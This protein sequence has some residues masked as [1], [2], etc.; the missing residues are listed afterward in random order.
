MNHS[1]CYSYARCQCLRHLLLVVFKP[2]VLHPVSTATYNS[3]DVLLDLLK[4]VTVLNRLCVKVVL[5][6]VDAS[7][8]TVYLRF[9]PDAPF[10]LAV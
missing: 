1:T 9:L 5:G 6:R 4:N 10:T 3:N 2:D 8:V 7:R